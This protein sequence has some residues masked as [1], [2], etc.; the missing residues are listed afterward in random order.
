MSAGIVVDARA[1]SESFAATPVW[2]EIFAIMKLWIFWVMGALGLG[3]VAG[4]GPVRAEDW[5]THRHDIGRSGVTAEAPGLPLKLAWHFV[6]SQPP[7]PAW[8][9]PHVIMLNRLDFDYAPQPVVGA[10]IVCFGS[11]TDDTVRALDE[12]TGVERW[13][14]TTGGPVRVAPQIAEGRVYFGSDAGLAYCVEA[15]TGRLV[16]SF[17]GAPRAEQV[18]GNHRMISRWPLRTGVLVDG[19][20]AFCVAGMW[21]SEGIYAWAL[22]AATGRVIWCNDTSG[23]AGVDYNHLLNATNA[24]SLE[25]GVHDGDFGIYGMTPQGALAAGREVLLV[26]N[27][28]AKPAGLDRRTGKLLFTEPRSGMGGHAVLVEG[29]KFYSAYSHRSGTLGFYVHEIATGKSITFL[30][31]QIPQLTTVTPRPPAPGRPAPQQARGKTSVLIQQGK[32]I[33][34]NAFSLVKAGGVLVL[35]VEDAVVAVDAATDQELWRAPVG[36]E[37]RELAVA[38]GRIIAATTRGDVYAFAPAGEVAAARV[39]VPAAAAGAL[40]VPEMSA[41]ETALVARL[42]ESGMDRGYALVLGDEDGALA[43]QLVART[44]LFCVSVAADATAAA[45]LRERWLGTTRMYGSR[46]QVQARDESGRLP[47]AQYFANAVVV[48]GS[49]RAWAAADLYRMVRPAGGVLLFNGT[50]RA[51]AEAF[52]RATGAPADEVRTGAAEPYLVRGKLPGALDWDSAFEADQRAKWPLRLLWFGGPTTAQVTDLKNN[53]PRAPAANGRYFVVGENTLTGLDAYNGRILWSRP[54]PRQS[55]DSRVTG[56]LVHNTDLVWSRELAHDYRR[57]LLVRGEQV[58]LTLG[59]SILGGKESVIELDARTGEQRKIFGAM[60]AVAGFSLAAPQTWKLPVDAEHS[61]EVTVAREAEAL[62]VTLRTRDPVVS[63]LDEWDLF[64]DL[65][66]PEARVGLY[67]RGV[68]QLRIAPAQDGRTAATSRTGTGAEHPAVAVS[69]TRDA[70]GTETVV[71]VPWAELEKMGGGWRGSFGF[72]A[73]LN[74]HDGRVGERIRQSF[75]FSNPVADGI[76]GGWANLAL[77]EGETVARPTLV[78]EMKAVIPKGRAALWPKKLDAGVS[79]LL[80]EHPL[81]GEAGPRFFQTGTGLCGGMDFSATTVIKRGGAAKLLSIYDFEDDSGL[82]NFVGVSAACGPST[83]VAQGLMIVS[84]AK[85]R[86]VCNYPFRTTVALAPAETRLN[87]DWAIFHDRQPDTVVRQAAINLGAFG[88]RRAAGGTLWLGFPRQLGAGEALGY[89]KVPGTYDDAQRP[90]VWPVASS[91]AMQVPLTVA[92]APGAGLGP[93]RW[94]ADRVTIA[95]T[96]EPWIYASGY[97]GL[98]RATLK[99]DFLPRLVSVARTGARA[100]GPKLDAVLAAGEWAETPQ[101]TLPGTK[102]RVWLAH[103]AETLYCA[104]TR[105]PIKDHRSLLPKPSKTAAPQRDVLAEDSWELFFSDAASG[106]VVHLALAGTGERWQAL[107][108]GDEKAED[109]TWA[110]AWQG[111]ARLDAAGFTAE[112]AVPLATLRAAG[113]DVRTL[114]INFQM[115]RSRVAGEALAYL[116]VTGRE[117]CLNFAPLTLGERGAVAARS[118]RVRLHFAEPD[119]VA[120]G[121]RVFDVKLQGRVVLKDFDVVREA[122]GVRRALVKTFAHVEAG[123]EMTLELVPRGGAATAGT[124]PILSGWEVVDQAFTPGARRTAAGGGKAQNP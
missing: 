54:I 109:A 43:R 78:A 3:G 45:A 96:G 74:S 12:R 95:G 87:E 2:L 82:R 57:V 89:A 30:R 16:W 39:H 15:A 68:F 108:A 46:V 10:G 19:G 102:T 105:P 50:E 103:D 41:E 58:F 81:T 91:A 107:G 11:S 73:T 90:G 67:E 51:E 116:G 118:F 32:M 42:R 33:G 44:E 115:N 7:S 4:V 123:A 24:A 29:N 37:V 117:R 124:A 71:R 36:G 69:G 52:L 94:N 98:R 110:G 23:F 49:P 85:S 6:A 61:G 112:V 104:V 66:A 92:I 35:G 106:R 122:G 65:R 26:P 25:H 70:R 20:V 9:P 111:A 18:S 97:R 47:F 88:D 55:V 75:L 53:N 38:N 8:P 13:H 80:R 40:A 100:P 72:A 14:F 5:P 63:E 1:G 62:V 79:A 93:Y 77:S 56:G 99:L 22:E 119:D 34:R 76:N 64:F 17:R 27:G 83:T 59:E 114:G 60:P 121:Q 31:G 86:C 101:V 48:T 120:A 21:A 113:L 28:Y 84:E